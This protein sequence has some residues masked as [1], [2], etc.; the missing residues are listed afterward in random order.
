[1]SYK[2][3]LYLLACKST[4]ILI[5]RN[6]FGDYSWVWGLGGDELL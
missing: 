4:I 6:I 2:R 1:M 5:E 3:P